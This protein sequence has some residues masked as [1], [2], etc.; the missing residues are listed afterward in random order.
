MKKM[1]WTISLCAVILFTGCKSSQLGA[2]D[3]LTPDNTNFSQSQTEYYENNED[4]N[5]NEGN[6]TGENTDKG[7]KENTENNKDQ[8]KSDD[9][10][11]K[12]I[13][14]E[15]V[16]NSAVEN[17]VKAGN[18]EI[19]SVT[20][21][22]GFGWNGIKKVYS[23]EEMKKCF[24]RLSEICSNANYNLSFSYEN[25]ETG[26]LVW[27]NDN[28]S[29]LTCSTIK[30]PYIKS[31][32]ARGIDLNDKIYRNS[33]WEG[34]DGTVASAPY[35]TEYTAKQLIEYTVNESDNT[36]YYL[37][38]QTYGYYDFNNMLYNLGANYALGDSW[39]FT[40]CT[41]A[42]MLKCY[43]DIYSFAKENKDGK[44]LTELMQNT[45]VT[46]Q[47]TQALGGK[48]KV[49]HKYGSEFTEATFN[50]CAIV[51][52]DSPFVLCIFTNQYPETEESSKVF[53]ELA[54]VFDDINSLIAK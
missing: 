1:I 32:L 45:E 24:D 36:A 22:Y 33:C 54:V 46:M 29:Y 12:K 49:S 53:R 28:K 7:Q 31:L 10:N 38:K 13:Y 51:Y 2:V 41:T 35:G 19:F 20:G 16:I 27:Y 8:N 9:S 26:A 3:R 44:W 18:T 23:N 47:I 39:I 43:A 30:A 17:A 21:G 15:P 5:S 14:D 37:L 50:D 6:T 40:H 11:S 48:Y 52:A 25:M 4:K 42:D 34:D